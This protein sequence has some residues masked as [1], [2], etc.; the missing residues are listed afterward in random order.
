[1]TEKKREETEVHDGMVMPKGGV[2]K[3]GKKAEDEG[4]EP[5]DVKPGTMITCRNGACGMEFMAGVDRCPYCNTKQ[6][7]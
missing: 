2:F 1:M 7:K 4:V 6:K 3:Q 5:H